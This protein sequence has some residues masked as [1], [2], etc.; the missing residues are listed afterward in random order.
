MNDFIPCRA[1]LNRK[2]IDPIAN[3]EDCGAPKETTFHA[4]VECNFALSLSEK[5]QSHDRDQTPSVMPYDLD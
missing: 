5:T 3:C 2:H 4:L 1:S